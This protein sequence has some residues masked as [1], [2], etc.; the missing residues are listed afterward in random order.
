MAD[1]FIS[2]ARKDRSKV[3]PIAKELQA[4]EWSVFWDRNIRGGTTWDE[5]IE[6][7]L[8]AAKC[9]IVVWTKNGVDSKWVRAEAGEGLNR[10]IL[11]PVFIEDLMPPLLFR[12]IQNIQLTDWNEDP[13]HRQFLKLISDLE[14][15]LGPSP[16]KKRGED[17]KRTEDEPETKKSF[18]EHRLSEE[19][20]KQQQAEET[21]KKTEIQSDGPTSLGI[22]SDG[23][24]KSR[25]ETDKP[26]SKK[27]SQNK[28]ISKILASLV[29]LSIVI[30]A[31]WYWNQSQQNN[32]IRQDLENLNAQTLNLE[33]EFEKLD[34]QEQIDKFVE[35]VDFLSNQA[36][37]IGEEAV[38]AGYQQQM[39][40]LNNNLER[41]RI[42]I[43]TK[44]KELLAV[45]PGRL[46][47]ATIPENSRVTI[48]DFDEQ[49]RQGMELKP[50]EY[51]IHLS[52]E[53]YEPH[54]EPIVL[55]SG[56]EKRIN[57][58]LKKGT[59]NIKF[60]LE[61]DGWVF[62]GEYKNEMWVEKYFGF[63]KNTNPLSLVQTR[64][65]TTGNVFIRKA[66]RGLF[67]EEKIGVLKAGDLVEI[68][69]VEKWGISN[70]WYAR[71]KY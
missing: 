59:E 38:K 36:S 45:Q 13:N 46:F 14:A 64:Q 50:G 42:L 68:I 62:L 3:E 30:I 37:D 34:N 19:A 51:V 2:Y 6:K 63:P 70:Y 26:R 25:P 31:I 15:I 32:K 33:S 69:Q 52:S 49:F 4:Q 16:L 47:V 35:H 8:N 7:E 11:V 56:E 60:V 23:F 57:I 41:L 9:V 20:G 17:K 39:E 24:V 18:E 40:K 22:G 12:P 58:E 61:R 48:L 53:G 67:K 65:K 5:V 29:V 71:I 66:M 43:A 28:K 1:I 27:Q 44:E 54:D 21:G 55:R 10:N